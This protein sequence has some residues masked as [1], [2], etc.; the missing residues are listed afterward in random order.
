MQQALI[1]R[2][3]VAAAINTDTVIFT[4][5]AG[6]KYKLLAFYLVNELAAQ[7]AG[8]SFE[9]RVGANIVAILGLD[10]AAAPIGFMTK[11]ALL[12]HE[13]VGDGQT[14][15]QVRNLVALNAASQVAYVVCYDSNYP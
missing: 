5:A 12:K 10:S 3:A 15:V 9:L 13:F 1:K 8:M 7:I 6:V 14:P 11:E 4:P 2:S